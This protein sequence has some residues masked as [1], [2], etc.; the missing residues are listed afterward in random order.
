MA[1]AWTEKQTLAMNTRDRT[2]L[3]SAAAGS[4][5]TATLTER[6]IRSILDEKDPISI[7]DM[8]IVTFTKA[9]TAEL[10]ERISKAIK[11]ALRTS[12][13]DE[14]LEVQLHLLSSA[15]IST[16][17]SLC[18]SILKSNCERVGLD[19]GYRIIDTAEAELL[20]ESLLDGM[21]HEIYEGNLSEVATP[22]ELM[23]L[24][25]C[26]TDTRTERD[27]SAIVRMFYDS[28]KDLV[29]GVGR[30]RTLV[31]EYDPGSFV[32]V[33]KTRLGAYAMN[34]VKRAA[35][36]HKVLIDEAIRDHLADGSPS[37][38]KK[39]DV[40]EGDSRF[41][42]SLLAAE[43]YVEARGIMLARVHPSTPNVS[44]A[45][46]MRYTTPMRKALK[47]DMASVRKKFLEYSPEEWL[48]SYSGLY[49]VLSVL[50]R[51]CE[52]FHS[53]FQAE[54]QRLAALEYSDVTRYTYECLW[55][56]GE[57]TDV[58]LSEAAKYRAVYIDEYQ[59]VNALQHM[60]FEA[61]SNEDNRF[62]VGDIKQSIY[63]FRGAEPGIFAKMKT[64]F[65]PIEKSS[66][67][68][69][70]TIFMSENFRC[71]KGV[72]DFTNEIFDN[73]FGTLKESIGFVPEDRL[74]YS[75]KHDG[76][77]PEYK[78]PEL[79]LL[80]YRTDKSGAEEDE[81]EGDELMPAVVAEK[82]AELLKTGRLDNGK[83]V[84]PGDIAIIMRNARGKDKKYAA[85][86]ERLG[87][88]VA[89]SDSVSFFLNPDVLLL[90]SILHA[91][92]NPR[93][94]I[95]LAAAM[96]SP[97]FGF[98]ADDMV[99]I[100]SYEQSTLYDNLLA[101]ATAAP[102]DK[103]A[104]R[105]LDFLDK[106][107]TAA[108]GMPVD[109]LIN[110]I[111]HDTGLIALAARRGGK[112]ELIRFYEYSRSFESSSY[113][114]LYNFL[115]YIKSIVGRKTEF[116][117]RDAIL[118]TDE[119][120]I[121]TAHASKGLEFPIVFFVESQ[122]PM[123]RKTDS[124]Q[125]LVY[126]IGFGISL[127]LRTPSGLSL[128]S[129]P[130]KEILLDYKLCRRIE[131]E[132]RVLYVILTR[133]REQ[134]YVVGKARSGFDAY[135]DKILSAHES[136]STHIAYSMSSYTDMITFSSG[137]S[138]LEPYEFLPSMSEE[139]KSKLYPTEAECEGEEDFDLPD[140]LPDGMLFPKTYAITHG[141]T[142]DKEAEETGE[143]PIG[144]LLARR[145][146]YEYPYKHLE[147][148]PKKLSVS[149]LYP[150][151]LDPDAKDEAQIS[152]KDGGAEIVF[153]IPEAEEI[154]EV[155]ADYGTAEEFIFEADELMPDT[156]ANEADGDRIT[157]MGKLP[158]FAT[159]SDET[160]S[161]RRGIATHL[162]F[163]FCDLDNLKKN[164]A[165]AELSRLKAGKYLSEEDCTRVRLK[166]VDAFCRSE[167]FEAM[168][169]AKRIWRELR[170]NA[171]LPASMF[172]SLPEIKE[173]LKGTNVLVQG[174]IDCLIED[175]SGELHLVD[176]KTDR[177][178]RVCHRKRRDR[179]CKARHRNASLLPVLRPR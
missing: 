141:I 163:Q 176:Y 142:E 133:A 31:S 45:P 175:D 88:P 16:I 177:L 50:V 159:G 81:D 105:M 14:R 40:L 61:I 66:A 146:S 23:Q 174:V 60:I 32:S 71:D 10:K 144:K 143:E 35:A 117:K 41:L 168:L 20:S 64:E 68:T 22:E 120:K 57:R 155:L 102:D 30:L 132:A 29:D 52:H 131:E 36:H 48:S 107:R 7:G 8:L 122:Q 9:A 62:M 70:S 136:L 15:R 104:R 78:K 13:G 128:V 111:L 147:R 139:L 161:A 116:D 165:E 1:R 85:A 42:A 170:F 178:M 34:A 134:L 18:S 11:D 114:G 149:R 158:R 69:D 21:F 17:D 87:I 130:T 67:G 49:S 157:K 65:C 25:D 151:I 6:I 73:L 154:S 145:F 124:M 138:F 103:K 38:A 113:R 72:I 123:K 79:C 90:L 97:V 137:T 112:G 96:C 43:T 169:G 33:E 115:N 37:L 173:K 171:A 4:G 75:K 47:D 26:L 172:T 106:Y 2:L 56:D 150:E 125:R 94:D 3:V 109:A 135:R 156:T 164:G 93:R 46:H 59:D 5:K 179:E 126:D 127:S 76:G 91:I 108:E 167:L 152:F 92:D 118:G 80:P 166:E 101:H 98:T 121:I 53:I 28:T 51:L 55:Q 140:T 148:L 95:Y 100:A 74:I 58:A 119:V 54:K 99:R 24:A 12:G 129:N 77:E 44:S 83:P 160:E 84:R 86:L 110:R 82:I 153:G 27:L 39:I 19:P 162:F 89:L 63:A